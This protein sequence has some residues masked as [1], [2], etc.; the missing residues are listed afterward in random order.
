MSFARLTAS[1]LDLSAGTIGRLKRHVLEASR[2]V[3]AFC[4]GLIAFTPIAALAQTSIFSGATSTLGSG[5][6]IPTGVAVDRNGNIYVADFNNGVVKEIAAVGGVIPANPTIRTLGSGF[7]SPY[8]VAVDNSG[9]VYVSDEG[10]SAVKEIGAIGGVIPVNPTIRAL[11]S[12]LNRPAGIAVDRSGNVYVADE[13]NSV[14]KEI[15]AVAGVIP[16]TPTILTLGSGFNSPYGVAVDLSGNVYVADAGNAAV[17][18]IEA[19]VGLIPPTPTILTLGSGFS[20]PYDVALDSNGNVYVADMN[21]SGV[22]EIEAVGGVI[23]ATPTILT[24]GSGFSSPFGVAVDGNGNVYVAGTSTDEIYEIQSNGVNFG[25]SAVAVAAPVTET[26]NFTFTTG[27]TIESPTVLTKGALNLDFTDAG[28]GTCTHGAYISTS[29]TVVINFVP[30][31]PGPRSGGVQLLNSAGAVIATANLYGTGVGPQMAYSPAVASVLGSGFSMPL[32]VAVDGSGNAYVADGGTNAVYQIEAVGGVI[33]SSPTIRT[34]SSSFSA[35]YGVAVDGSGNVYVADVNN[36]A[37]KE[38]EA[39]GGVF[40]ANPTILILGSGFNEPAGVAVDGSGN[41]YVADIG[42][43]AVYEIEAAGGV[44]PANP[45][46]LTLG[47]GFTSPYGVA[48]D[49]SGNVYVAD[50]GNS[51]VYEIEA[52]GGVI[53][54]SPTIRTLGSNFSFPYG[55]A[56]DG[57]GNVYVADISNSAVYEIEAVGGAIPVNPTIRTWGSGFNLPAGVAVDGGGN[58]YVT[59]WGNSAVA[60]I[61]ISIAQAL[62]FATATND[63]STDTTDGAQQVTVI[64]NGNGPLSAAAPGLSVS[65]NFAQVAGSGT[66]ADCTSSF[67]LAPGESCNLSLEFEPQIDTPSGSV[68]GSV[69]LTDNNLNASP[70]VSQTVNLV[71]TSVLPPVSATQTVASTTLAFYQSAASL[72]PVTGSDG[73]APLSYSV[74][75]ALPAGLR[76]STATGIITGAATVTSSAATYNVTVMDANDATAMA[77]FSLAVTPQASVTTVTTNLASATPAQTVIFSATVTAVI[78][79]T[80][81]TPSGTVTFFDGTTQ[82]GPAT[83]L[84]NGMV[85]VAVSGLPAGSTATVSAVYS[86]SG[87]FLSSIS[88]SSVPVV[89][90]PFDLSFTNTGA[91]ANTAAAGSV[92]TYNFG[93]AP[94]YGS[95]P[96]P[97]TLTVTG[98]PAGATASFTPTSVAVGGGATAVTMTVQT[99]STVAQSNHAGFPFGRGIMLAL[100]LLPFV[101]KRGL[102]RMLRSKMLLVLLSIGL[103]AALSG[104]GSN[105]VNPQTYTLTATATSG[106]LQ[107]SQIVTLVVQ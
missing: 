31:H 107:H 96:G 5:F 49:G 70:G 21:N 90:A 37:V 99:L 69:V 24:L 103:A 57:N 54:A 46:I 84:V 53:P 48:V 28:T 64:N 104:C 8:D 42:N 67:S 60:E 41:I 85:Q 39:V 27:A 55:V 86:G 50:M 3:A 92:A 32:G 22:K 102:R 25:S 17:K 44:I 14:V 59:Q 26:L 43:S 98:L 58:I 23:P 36:R 81:T 105:N 52:A 16:P 95:Y 88:S 100:L 83:S 72:Q 91:S 101:G 66:P 71:G 19:V 38:I 4:I 7:T 34:L 9:N 18:E 1:H 33:P 2:G 11:G 56:V 63:G 61:D 10:N 78:P 62:T 74:S 94:L 87:S 35:P 97:V 29:C 82:L 106:A 75:P 13:G 76:F 40:P 6:S 47:S 12:G 89:V 73:M 93:L 65:W 15:E 45:T 80:P 30:T 68:N 79:G 20:A 51:A 77:S